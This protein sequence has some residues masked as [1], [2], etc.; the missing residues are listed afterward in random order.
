MIFIL[1]FYIAVRDQV[2]DVYEITMR[3]IFKKVL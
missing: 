3:Y 2:S 1:F